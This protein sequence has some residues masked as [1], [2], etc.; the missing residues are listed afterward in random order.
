MPRQQYVASK[1]SLTAVNPAL[2]KV[3]ASIFMLSL[4]ILALAAS[5]EET[6]GNMAAEKT[7]PS[8]FSVSPP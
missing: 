8:A 1:A 6:R 7:A 5:Q 3:P 2:M 4:M